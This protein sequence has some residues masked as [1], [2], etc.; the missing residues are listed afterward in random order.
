MFV[1]RKEKIFEI[2][3]IL[4]LSPGPD[5]QTCA[6]SHV[7]E[8]C[9]LPRSF[10][11][12]VFREGIPKKMKQSNFYIFSGHKCPNPQKVTPSHGLRTFGNFTPFFAINFVIKL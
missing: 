2:K 3:I 10:G 4:P 1:T 12:L 8:V 7:V 11:L 6:A 5:V 9:S